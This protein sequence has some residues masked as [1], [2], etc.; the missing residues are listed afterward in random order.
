MKK[1]VIIILIFLFTFVKI[2][3]AQT[4]LWGM[5]QLGGTSINCGANGCGTIFKINLDGTGYNIPYN[6]DGINGDGPCG[7]LMQA[8]NGKLYGLAFGGV[9]NH[10]VLFSFDPINNVYNDVYDFDSINGSNPTGTL[11]QATDGKLYGMANSGGA[12][13][14]YGVLFSYDPAS[15]IYN[16]LFDFNDTLGS[17]PL[18]RLI[19]A[20]NGKLYGMTQSGG[21]GSVGVLFSF[22]IN[23]HTYLDI[24]DFNL[25][26][27]NLPYGSLIQ[28][29]NGKLYGMTQWNGGNGYGVLF[30]FDPVSNTFTD[31]FDFN[32]STGEFPQGSLIQASNGKLYG[33]TTQGGSINY[34]VLFSFDINSNS[35]NVLINF[36]GSTNGRQPSGGLLQASNGKLYGMTNFGGTYDNGILF[37]FDITTTILTKLRNLNLPDG[38][39]PLYSSFIEIADSTTNINSVKEQKI[40]II[41]Y[42]NPFNAKI[43]IDYFLTDQIPVTITIYNTL[44]E[45]VKDLVNNAMQPAGDYKIIFDGSVLNAGIYYYTIIEGKDRK[46]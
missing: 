39:Q 27:G 28:A 26:T 34:G 21:S 25:A 9:N 2:I 43:E 46:S 15:G 14:Y 19:Q 4:K 35:Y 16:D 11:M 6:F 31:L 37:S 22:D 10:G 23:T 13:H 36:I 7:S 44:G 40:H 42:P 18:G 1:K 8:T 24:L 5:T 33:M 3:N 30:S 32:T 29:S 38:V 17:Y 45:K 41:A 12:Y 20:T